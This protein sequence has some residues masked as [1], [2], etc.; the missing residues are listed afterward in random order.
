MLLL[1][2]G[3]RLQTFQNEDLQRL[4]S[5]SDIDLTL[6]GKQPC[7]YYI[8]TDDMN[9]SLWFSKLTILYIFVYK[10]S[11]VCRF[12]TKWKMR[13]RCFLFFRRICEYTVKFPSLIRRSAL[14]EAEA[15]GL[16]VITQNK[17]QMDSRY[18]N[19]MSD[20]IIR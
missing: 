8:I 18:P 5:A 10:I 9:R 15:Y 11:K 19:K 13:C 20:E 17:S 7:I 3:T 16:I 12:K 1:G 14:L 2:L 4:T 6:P